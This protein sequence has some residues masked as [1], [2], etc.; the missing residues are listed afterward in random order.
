MSLKALQ[1]EL[2]YTKYI[3]GERLSY[4]EPSGNKSQKTFAQELSH[5]TS[6]KQ[7]FF[8]EFIIEWKVR[9]F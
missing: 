6:Q 3:L 1:K 8:M 2:G 5:S 9:C 4:Y 7:K